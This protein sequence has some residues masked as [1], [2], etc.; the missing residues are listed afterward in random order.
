MN[1]EKY[2]QKIIF[3]ELSQDLN[4]QIQKYL[5]RIIQIINFYLKKI[6]IIVLNIILKIKI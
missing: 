1:L 3:Q 2:I 5:K 4:L 6:I